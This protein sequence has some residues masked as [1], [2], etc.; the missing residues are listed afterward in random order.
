MIRP[1][2]SRITPLADTWGWLPFLVLRFLLMV[3]FIMGARVNTPVMKTNSQKMF[4]REAERLKRKFHRQA[5]LSSYE[6]YDRY[7][8]WSYRNF[9]ILEIDAPYEY[10]LLGVMGNQSIFQVTY[11]NDEFYDH[12]HSGQKESFELY[13]AYMF[14]HNYQEVEERHKVQTQLARDNG[15]KYRTIPWDDYCKGPDLL[16]RGLTNMDE[17]ML[18]LRFANHAKEFVI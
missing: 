6:F 2:S 7:R 17:A 15:V 9:R 8:G 13:A 14:Y 5:V 18:T 11:G 12:W 4:A 16:I 10:D 3:I 1:I